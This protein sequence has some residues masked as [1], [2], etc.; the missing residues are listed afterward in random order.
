MATFIVLMNFTEQGIKA[1]KGSP[2]RYEEFLADAKKLG[3]NVK[4]VYWTVGHYDL[5]TTLEGTDEAVTTV[6]LKLG[7]RGNVRTE[8]LRGYSVDEM[9]GL[10]GKLG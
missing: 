7:S 1:V 10:V 3:V 8:T 5:V 4:S 2:G 9:K 6:L